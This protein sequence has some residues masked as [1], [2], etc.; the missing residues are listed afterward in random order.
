MSITGST[1]KGVVIDSRGDNRITMAFSILGSVVG[2]TVI[3]E[4]ECVAKTFPQ[5]WDILKSIGGK[6][7]THE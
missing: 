1:A 4:A 2:G 7:N 6:V 5:F 3:D